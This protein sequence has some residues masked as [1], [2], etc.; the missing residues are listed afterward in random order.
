M[1]FVT[2]PLSDK[3]TIGKSIN[4]HNKIVP[5]L[6]GINDNENIKI[7]DIR[8]VFVDFIEEYSYG[9]KKTPNNSEF[10]LYV[11]EN[12]REIDIFPYQQIDRKADSHS[13]ILNTNDLIPNTYYID[14]RIKNGRTSNVFENVVNFSIVSNVTN[15]NK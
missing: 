8:E 6:Y 1:E 15:F 12:N 13:F 14:I 3:L 9:K 11:K 5:Q 10:R 4:L 7:G 2:L